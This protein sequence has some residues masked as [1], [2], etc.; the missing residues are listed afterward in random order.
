VVVSVA[1]LAAIGT[2]VLTGILLTT[3]PIRFLR[4]TLRND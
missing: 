3:S 1:G 2:P 4:P